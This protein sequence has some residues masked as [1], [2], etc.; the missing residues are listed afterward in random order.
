MKFTNCNA[1]N[2]I[3]WTKEV[4]NNYKK[5]ITVFTYD[6]GELNEE[7]CVDLEEMGIVLKTKIGLENLPDEIN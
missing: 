1:E 3:R 5:F 6:N 7:R 4:K 2:R